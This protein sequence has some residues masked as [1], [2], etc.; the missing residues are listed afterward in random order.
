LTFEHVV[1]ATE[2]RLSEADVLDWKVELPQPPRDGAWNEFAK[3]VAAMANTRGGLLVYGVSDDKVLKGIDATAVAPGTYGQW[4]RNHVRPFLTGVSY[5]VL[6]SA[7]GTPAVLLVEVA[8][9]EFAPHSVTGTA[10]R[11]KQQNAFVVPF[12]DGDHTAWMEEHQ[13][14]RAYRDRFAGQERHDEALVSAWTAT[15]DLLVEPRAGNDAWLIIAAQP[16]RPLPRLGPILL[17][18]DVGQ[19]LKRALQGG[20]DLRTVGNA[21]SMALHNLGN[22]SFNA[23]VGLRSWVVSNAVATA[24]AEPRRG[25]YVQL[26]HEGVFTFAV[27]VS[28]RTLPP[29][30]HLHVVNDEVVD[31]ASG[32]AISL[33]QVLAHHLHH[34]SPIGI[35]AGIAARPNSELNYVCAERDDIGNFEVPETSR[36]PSRPALDNRSSPE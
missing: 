9:S 22:Q 13:I 5:E 12:R 29:D 19:I 7:D 32:E 36:W 33:A 23:R 24:D 31:V 3:D 28:A 10:A 27:N 35:R 2:A 1:A 18:Q 4:L 15:H 11:D 6:V 30:S 25:V 8:P 14:A 26:G 16:I 17:R 21:H 34:D 20:A